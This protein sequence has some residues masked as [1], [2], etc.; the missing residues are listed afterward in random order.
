MPPA[1]AIS[2]ENALMAAYVFVPSPDVAMM[3]WFAPPIDCLYWAF[4]RHWKRLSHAQNGECHSG[5]ML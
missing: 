5:S 1:I 3:A 4:A 2:S